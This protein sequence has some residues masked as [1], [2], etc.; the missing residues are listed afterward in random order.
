MPLTSGNFADLLK[1]GLKSIFDIVSSRPRPMIDLL[2]S[3]ETSTRY[4]EQYA[5]GL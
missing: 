3:V 5:K 1:P 2:F 4:E